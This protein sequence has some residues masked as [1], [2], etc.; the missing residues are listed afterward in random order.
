MAVHVRLSRHGTRNRPFYHVVAADHRMRRDGRFIE[1][2]GV[3]DP[4][5]EPSLFDV[6]HDR[7][8]FWYERGAHLSDTVA[9]LLKVKNVKLE[10]K[11]TAKKA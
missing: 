2:L 3:Y 10:R 11:N 5:Q 4:G 1:K 6:K 7:L 9:K 8:Q